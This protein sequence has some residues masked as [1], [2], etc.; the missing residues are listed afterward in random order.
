MCKVETEAAQFP[1]L[2][3]HKGDFRCRA[4]ARNAAKSHNQFKIPH[5]EFIFASKSADKVNKL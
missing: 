2:E 3:I 5:E 1:F 4:G